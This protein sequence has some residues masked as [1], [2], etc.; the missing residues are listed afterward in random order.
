LEIIGG[1]GIEA[2]SGNAELRGGFGGRQRVLPEARE[3]MADERR[4]MTIG[5]LLVLFKS[6]ASLHHIPKP[7][8]FVGLRY[9]PASSRTG[10]GDDPLGAPCTIEIVLVC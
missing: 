3:H 8:P 10:L 2:A 6:I 7:S 9:A 4:G 1:K 5:Y